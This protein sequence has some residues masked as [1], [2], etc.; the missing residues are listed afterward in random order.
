MQKKHIIGVVG[1]VGPYAGLDLVKKIFDQTTASIDQ[2][3]LP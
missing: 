3:H 2:E 1:G